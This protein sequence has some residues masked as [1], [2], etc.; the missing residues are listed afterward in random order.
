MS[1]EQSIVAYEDAKTKTIRYEVNGVDITNS[2]EILKEQFLNQWNKEHRITTELSFYERNNYAKQI[3]DLEAKLAESEEESKA[4]YK[5][6]QEE[7]RACDELRVVLAEVRKQLA[8]KELKQL[9]LDLRMYKSVNEFL[10]RYG[11][12]KAREVLL[13]TEKTKYQDK[14]SFALEQLEKVKEWCENHKYS[15]EDDYVITYEPDEEDASGCVDYLKDF[16][17]NQI[18]QLKEMK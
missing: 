18:K 8:E 3:S 16:I 14:I 17:D 13:Q 2:V 1:K 6:W 10:N 15:D 7:I 5:D 9:K 4:R 12:E 11:I